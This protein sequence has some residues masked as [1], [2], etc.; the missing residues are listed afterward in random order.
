MTLSDEHHH[1]YDS[2]LSVGTCAVCEQPVFTDQQAHRSY[3]GLHHA[4]CCKDG[5]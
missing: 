5:D 1:P 3:A 4:E 2:W